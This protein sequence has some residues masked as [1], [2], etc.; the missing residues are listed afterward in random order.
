MIWQGDLAALALPVGRIV[1]LVD[2]SR[3]RLAGRTVRANDVLLELRRHQPVPAVAMPAEPGVPVRPP[4]WPDAVGTVH[5]FD[6]PNMGSPGAASARILIAAAGSNDGWRGADCWFVPTA[7]AEPIALGT[8]RPAGA[9]GHLAEPLARSSE[10]LIDGVNTALVTLVNP[11]MALESVDDAALLSGAN[12]A[13]VGGELLQFGTAEV[14]GPAIWRLSRLLRGQ[15]GTGSAAA[16][17]VG[18]PFVLLDDSAPMLLPEALA[19]MAESGGARLQWAP[20][21]GATMTEVPVPAAGGALLP[22]APVHGRISSDG[23]GGVC[24][25]WRRRS[26]VDTGWR[27]HV[28]LPIGEGQEAWRISLSPPIPGFAPW[29]RASP[30]LHIA[31]AVL[32]ALPPDTMIAIRQVGDFG[33]SPPL[34]LSLT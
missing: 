13:M 22:L 11:S 21:G 1:T 3:W 33:L 12:R 28:D 7:D 23:S 29:D 14:V 10:Y 32:A 18:A 15:A 34:S 2:G 8:V 20:R 9:L 5:L 24:V 17:T 4:D 25:S 19:I 31:A 30:D 26:R 27:D 16:H 6:L